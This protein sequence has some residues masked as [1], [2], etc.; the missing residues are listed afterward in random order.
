LSAVFINTTLTPSPKESH[1]DTLMD[2]VRSIMSGAGVSVRSFRSVDHDI[3]PGVQPDMTKHGFD[4][5]DWPA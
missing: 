3:A 5:D 2:V 4:K 1:T